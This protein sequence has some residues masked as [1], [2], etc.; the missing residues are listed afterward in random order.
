MRVLRQFV[1]RES[2]QDLLEYVLLLALAVLVTTAMLMTA[3]ESLSAVWDAPILVN[4]N[5]S[6]GSE[7]HRH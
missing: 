2:G 3:G 5:S 6:S 4:A 7:G 1:I